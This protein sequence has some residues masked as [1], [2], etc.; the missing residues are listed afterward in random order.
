[1]KKKQTTD[2]D[3]S[4]ISPLI[5][6]PGDIWTQTTQKLK[7]YK[8]CMKIIYDYLRYRRIANL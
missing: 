3:K 6:F 8:T 7:E 4:V 5:T 1:M 2:F